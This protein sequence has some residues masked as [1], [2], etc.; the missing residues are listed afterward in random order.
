MDD[1]NTAPILDSGVMID[2]ALAEEV[3]TANGDEAAAA[4][5]LGITRAALRKRL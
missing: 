5:R 3:G 2:R 4:K 1:R